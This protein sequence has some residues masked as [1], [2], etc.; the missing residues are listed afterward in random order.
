RLLQPP[1][2]EGRAGRRS[3]HHLCRATSR[4]LYWRTA[5]RRHARQLALQHVHPRRPPPLRP[6]HRRA[7]QECGGLPAG[8]AG[9]VEFEA[10]YRP[11][12]SIHPCRISTAAIRSTALA[13][14]SIERSASRSSRFASAEVNRSSHKC[15]GRRNRLR[16]SSANTCIL[17]DCVPS[18]PLMRSGNPTTISRT[19]YS[20]I[21][22]SSAAKSVRLL[23]RCKVSSPCAVMPRGSD[24]AIPIRLD[25]TS[26]P[27]ILPTALFFEVAGSDVASTEGG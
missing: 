25:P 8:D 6:H 15:T 7:Q 18:A 5:P 26:S 20:R 1:G 13:R 16:N 3:Q 14:F 24:I 19:E 10:I 21:T 2:K 17:S 22:A 9:T 4:N 23:R 27:R 12:F 11:R